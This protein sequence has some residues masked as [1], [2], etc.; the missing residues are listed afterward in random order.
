MP[1][2][3]AQLIDVQSDFGVFLRKRN[4]LPEARAVLDEALQRSLLLLGPDDQATLNVRNNLG[5]VAVRQDDAARAEAEFL[6]ILAAD[7]RGSHANV[8][9]V[10]AALENL[11]ALYCNAGRL[12]EA[13]RYAEEAVGRTPS[14]DPKYAKRV[15]NLATIRARIAAAP[16]APPASS[17][18]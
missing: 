15:S 1:G 8:P 10:P 2:S 14:S 4:R 5:C 3:Q 9:A 6:E 16:A 17:P 7:R 11:G 18:P 12:A 13:E